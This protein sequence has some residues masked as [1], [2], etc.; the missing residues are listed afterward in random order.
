MNEIVF[1]QQQ[2]EELKKVITPEQIKQYENLVT[3]AV[4][5]PNFRSNQK[6]IQ[7]L[8]DDKTSSIVGG[9][10]RNTCRIILGMAEMACG[11]MLIG[12]TIYDM[13]ISKKSD[14]TQ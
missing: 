3:L 6:N 11:S 5:S 9:I 12:K 13:L 1:T 2:K 14:S 10:D 8:T 7:E 4:N